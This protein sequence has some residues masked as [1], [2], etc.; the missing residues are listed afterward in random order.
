MKLSDL[1]RNHDLWVQRVN[2]LHFLEEVWPYWF[3]IG[4]ESSVKPSLGCQ[5]LE[6]VVLESSQT[7]PWLLNWQSKPWVSGSWVFSQ[8]KPW[9]PARQL[10]SG[11]VWTLHQWSLNLLLNQA[12]AVELSLLNPKSVVLDHSSVKPSQARHLYY[13]IGLSVLIIRMVSSRY[14]YETRSCPET[15]TFECRGLTPYTFWRKFDPNSLVPYWRWI[16]CQTKPWLM[17]W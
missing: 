1:S 14:S 16:L 17:N 7:K 4:V 12:L 15:M 13:H 5:N 8:T 2:P 11:Q 9:L 10:D 3:H 6:S